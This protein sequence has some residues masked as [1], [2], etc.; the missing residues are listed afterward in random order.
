LSLVC[1]SD[2]ARTAGEDGLLP[3]ARIGCGSGLLVAASARVATAEAVAELRA[4]I[5]PEAVQ[6]LLAFFSVA[7]DAETLA[8]ALA[9]A[10]PG[11]PVSGCSTAGEI[12]PDGMMNGG[13]VAI[14]FPR[15]GFRVHT[16]LIADVERFGVGRANEIV[17]KLKSRIRAAGDDRPLSERAF[18]LMLVDGLCNREEMLVA[19]VNWAIDDIQLV[20]GSAG[21]G[22]AFRPTR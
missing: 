6:H 3:E 18:A 1:R 4:A 17:R 13:V 7:H 15:H 9:S 19:A 21:D 20:D 8:A 14:G 5:A 11:V 16:D 2:W 22:L 12:G 10:F